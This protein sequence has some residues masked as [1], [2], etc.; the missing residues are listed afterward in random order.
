[1]QKNV[2]I[3][4]SGVAALQLATK[5]NHDFYVTV[6]TKST[7]TTSNSYLAQGGIAAALSANDHAIK[8]FQDTLEAGRF[9]NNSEVVRMVTEEAPGLIAELAEDG[10]QFDRDQ[11]GQLKLGMEGAHSTNRIVHGGGDATGKTIIDFLKVKMNDQL[12]VVEHITVF[13]LIIENNRCIGVKGKYRDNRIKDFYADHVVLATGG[14]GQIYSFTSNAKTVTG[15]GIALAYRAGAKLVDMEFVQFHPTLLAVNGEGVGLVSEAVRGEGARLVTEEGLLIMEGVHEL[16]DLAPRHIVSQTIYNYIK[17]GQ[18]VY[19]DISS[20][21]QFD[22]R[23]P[24]V[25][26]ICSDHGIDFKEGRIP[27][28]PGCHFLMG[29]ISTDINGCTSVEGLYAIGEVACTGIHGANRLASNSLLEGLVFGQRLAN[30]LN[31]HSGVS[32]SGVQQEYHTNKRNVKKPYHL[33][34]KSTLQKS[35]MDRTGI[36]RDKE[37]LEKQVTFLESYQIQEWL[38][39]DLE[40]LSL[41]EVETVFM[42][43][44][45]WLVTTSALQRTESRGGHYR[46]DFPNEVVTWQKVFNIQQI[47]DGENV[48]QIKTAIAT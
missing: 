47:K 9:H 1:M 44:A 24:T 37:N 35:M 22:T 15:D 45:S 46:T 30:Y 31:Q 23:F 4:G 17:N 5:L 13:D 48:E 42:L 29:G 40:V 41:D 32:V 28:V 19:L 34:D 6:L 38:K 7:L 3:I 27:V 26:A 33:P 14:L 21:T 39:A 18:K 20:I 16:K 43:I 12:H 11:A 2:L 10:C 8:H 36:V 25:A